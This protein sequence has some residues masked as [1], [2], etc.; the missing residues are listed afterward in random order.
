MAKRKPSA[1]DLKEIA[2][3]K[4][5]AR[6]KAEAGMGSRAKKRGRKKRVASLKAGR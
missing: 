2:T 4:A 5:S 1:R 3:G 6:D